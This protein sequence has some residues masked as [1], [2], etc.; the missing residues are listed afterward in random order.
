MWADVHSCRCLLMR[1]HDL[2]IVVHALVVTRRRVFVFHRGARV[3][4][5]FSTS[6]SYISENVVTLG[7]GV[8]QGVG[9]TDGWVNSGLNRAVS[10][11]APDSW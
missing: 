5:R 6:A 1:S 10:R 4:R 9:C 7:Q 11:T 3:V 8:V 2:K